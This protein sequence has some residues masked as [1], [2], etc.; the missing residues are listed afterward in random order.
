MKTLI[1]SLALLLALPLGA[2]AKPEL[3]VLVEPSPPHNFEPPSENN[4]ISQLILKVKDAQSGT[5]I[6]GC[7]LDLSLAHDKSSLWFST[8]FPWVEGKKLL[9]FTQLQLERSEYSFSYMFPVRGQY[10]LLATT[11]PPLARPDLFQPFTTQ[12]RIKVNEQAFE[13]RNIVLFGTAL[14]LVGFLPALLLKRWN[15]RSL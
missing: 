5:S 1:L 6:D 10:I 11:Y 2:I 14:F 12:R 4:E 3:S 13:V 7:R 15:R 8:G 9:S